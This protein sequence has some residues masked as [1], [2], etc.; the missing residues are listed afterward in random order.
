MGCS[1]RPPTLWR[2]Q[3][4]QASEERKPAEHTEVSEASMRGFSRGLHVAVSGV[5]A[6]GCVTWWRSYVSSVECMSFSGD[7]MG[8][9]SK[10]KVCPLQSADVGNG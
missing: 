8:A 4:L 6:L 10:K 7:E 5:S 9:L 1:L 3:N 2:P